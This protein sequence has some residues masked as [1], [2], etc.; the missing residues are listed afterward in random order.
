ML[1][2]VVSCEGG[3]LGGEGTSDSGGP[4]MIDGGGSRSREGGVDPTSAGIDGE[5]RPSTTLGGDDDIV[6][7]TAMEAIPGDDGTA[8]GPVT[9]RWSCHG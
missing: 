2:D 9:R 4:T 1:G 5:L 3:T 8:F 6:P 7:R